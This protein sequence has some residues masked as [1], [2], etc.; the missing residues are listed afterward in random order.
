MKYEGNLRSW[1][2]LSEEE[3]L[4]FPLLYVWY[5]KYTQHISTLKIKNGSTIT[6]LLS[7]LNSDKFSVPT[8]SGDPLAF[9]EIADLD[10]TTAAFLKKE[11]V[12]PSEEF[13]FIMATARIAGI[14]ST[15]QKAIEKQL[16][17]FF[18]EMQ[19]NKIKLKENTNERNARAL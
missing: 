6:D 8:G 11:V 12:N 18:P 19:I 14:F 10:F 2:E 17:S 5:Y 9:C 4:A 1:G 16:D 15:A 3:R 13:R 7:E